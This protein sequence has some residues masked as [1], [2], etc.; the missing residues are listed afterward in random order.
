VDE[1]LGRGESPAEKDPG[2]DEVGTVKEEVDLSEYQDF[3]DAFRQIGGPR[4]GYNGKRIHSA[5]DYLTPGFEQ[6]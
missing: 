4:G 5:L 2:E 1:A 3:A 6:L